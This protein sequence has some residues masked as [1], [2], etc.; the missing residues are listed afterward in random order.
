MRDKGK[1]S[2]AIIV[3]KLGTLHK[4]AGSQSATITP[5]AQDHHATDKV[6]LKT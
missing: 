1:P 6:V 5:P 2:L 3:E 4:I